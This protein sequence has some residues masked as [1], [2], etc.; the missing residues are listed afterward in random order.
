[1]WVPGTVSG[2]FNLLSSLGLLEHFISLVFRKKKNGSEYIKTITQGWWVENCPEAIMWDLITSAAT[3]KNPIHKIIFIKLT[4]FFFTV[5]K[6]ELTANTLC[7]VAFP[8]DLF[9]INYSAIK[10]GSLYCKQLPGVLKP[11]TG[12]TAFSSDT[13]SAPVAQQTHFQM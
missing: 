13:V 12:A 7:E 11:Q 4:D 8:V 5:F 3:K 10:K 9:C 1:M 2:Q 6:L